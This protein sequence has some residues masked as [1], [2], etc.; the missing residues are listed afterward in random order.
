MPTLK[1]RKGPEPSSFAVDFLYGPRFLRGLGFFS[2]TSGPI[3]AG[4]SPLLCRI[5]FGA[6]YSGA[7]TTRPDL[8]CRLFRVGR[9]GLKLIT[10]TIVSRLGSLWYRYHMPKR[11]AT[12]L[13]VDLPTIPPGEYVFAFK[14]R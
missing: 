12:G 3:P 6:S 2:V 11:D 10:Q 8:S 7:R 13:T 4:V 9:A 14:I 1:G 5:S